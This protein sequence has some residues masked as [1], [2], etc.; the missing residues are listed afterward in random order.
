M[1]ARPDQ[2]HLSHV[3]GS[4]GDSLQITLMDVAPDADN[5][6]VWFNSTKL[7]L[8]QTEDLERFFFLQQ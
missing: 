1:C 2:C 7:G 6:T 3:Q 4:A 5:L 8:F